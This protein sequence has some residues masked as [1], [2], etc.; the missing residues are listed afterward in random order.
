MNNLLIE[1]LHDEIEFIENILAYASDESLV[2]LT[3]IS[4]ADTQAKSYY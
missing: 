2:L 3:N 4:E 1:A